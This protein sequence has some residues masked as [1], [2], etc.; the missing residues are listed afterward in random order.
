MPF[1]KKTTNKIQ[2][3]QTGGDFNNPSP[4]LKDVLHIVTSAEETSKVV[5]TGFQYTV[6]INALEVFLNGQLLRC[7][8]TIQGTDYGDYEETSNFT[9]TFEAGVVHTGD[10]VR[11]RV[12]ANSYDYS[13]NNIS[14]LNQIGKDQFGD[15][16]VLQGSAIR[17][18][19]TIG[20]I[21]TG[22][23]PDISDY[24]TYELSL[25]GATDITDFTGGKSD[26]IRYFIFTNSNATIKHG[27][28]IKLAGGSDFN[29]TA[30]DTLQ[31][32]YDGS[33]WYEVCRS[34]NG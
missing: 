16:Y 33:I 10:Q 25:S 30:N 3:V 32:I 24:R 1:I 18:D 31:L 12:T 19:R 27:T 14:N 4:V 8:E 23:T 21:T 28:T 2:S 26:D 9:V 11:F 5:G 7:K 6:G 17:S 15:S 22:T 29:G 13:N 34:V 20:E